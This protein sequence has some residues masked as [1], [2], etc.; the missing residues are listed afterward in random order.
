MLPW[1]G[2][3]VTFHTSSTDKKLPVAMETSKCVFKLIE[4]GHRNGVAACN[5]TKFKECRE[6]FGH[7]RRYM[8]SDRAEVNLQSDNLLTELFIWS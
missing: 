5:V 8:T 7:L 4:G 1:K 3:T 6:A 2:N